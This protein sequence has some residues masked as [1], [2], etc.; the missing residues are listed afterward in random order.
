MPCTLEHDLSKQRGI[1]ELEMTMKVSS[2]GYWKA[3][4]MNTPSLLVNTFGY[5]KPTTSQGIHGPTLVKIKNAGRPKRG[6]YWRLTTVWKNW[7]PYLQHLQTGSQDFKSSKKFH[8][9]QSSKG[10]KCFVESKSYFPDTLRLLIYLQLI[11][12]W[13]SLVHELRDNRFSYYSI[14]KPLVCSFLSLK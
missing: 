3:G 7:F 10:V 9:Q 1:F 4:P 12:F 14:Q 2:S 5:M 11:T 13:S 6:R 8:S